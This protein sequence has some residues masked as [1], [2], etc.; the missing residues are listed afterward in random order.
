K[1]SVLSGGEKS[2]VA[3]AKTLLSPRN[4]LVLDEPTNHL[5]IQSRNVLIEALRQYKGTFLVVSHDRHFLD[6]VTNRI[7]YA[8]KGGIVTYPGTYSEFRY[9]QNLYETAETEGPDESG[10]RGMNGRKSG[11][12]GPQKSQDE[13]GAG[14]RLEAEKRN[15][16]YRE[17][18]ERGIEN[19]ENWRELSGKQLRSAL[20][21][22]EQRING[23]EKNISEVEAF[24]ADP[25]NFRDGRRSAEASIE[26]SRLSGELKKLYDR[27][28]AVS[29]HLE[30][31]ASN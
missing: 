12:G 7:W 15:L 22:L 21:E 24:L 5:D 13:S 30:T 6:R 4:F 18:R 29:S 31:H 1:V 17:L 27:W 19:M 3:L 23:I 20:A 28:E 10:E 16:L 25:E 26:F 9:H 11:V 2:R 8:E 14:R